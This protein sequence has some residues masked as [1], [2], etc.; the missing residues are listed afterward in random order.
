MPSRCAAVDLART[1]VGPYVTPRREVLQPRHDARAGAPGLASEVAQRALDDLVR[2]RVR[3]RRRCTRRGP[4]ARGR[5]SARRSRPRAPLRGMSCATSVGRVAATPK[6]ERAEERAVRLE[7][8][9]RLAR[10]TRRSTC[11]GVRAAPGR[12]SSRAGRRDGGRSRRARRRCRAG[13]GDGDVDVVLPDGRVREVRETAVAGVRAAVGRLDD[14][15]AL[16]ALP[17]GRREERVAE[18][19]EAADDAD[20]ARVQLRDAVAQVVDVLRRRRS[21]RPSGDGRVEAHLARLVLEVDLDRVDPVLVD[22]LDHATAQ[23]RV[24]PAVQ[25]DVH[26]AYR[27]GGRRGMMSTAHAAS[28]AVSR[29]ID[30]LQQELSWQRRREARREATVVDWAARPAISRRARARPSL[31]NERLARP[32]GGGT[33]ELD[34]RRRRVDGEAPATRRLRAEEAAA[35][36]DLHSMLP[37]SEAHRGEASGSSPCV[38]PS[39]RRRC[40]RAVHRTLLAPVTVNWSFARRAASRCVP[41]AGPVAF[42]GGAKTL[43]APATEATRRAIA[44]TTASGDYAALAD[45]RS[46]HARTPGP[47]FQPLFRDNRLFLVQKSDTSVGSI[48]CSCARG[49]GRSSRATIDRAAD[50][51][52]AV[53]PRRAAVRAHFKAADRSSALARSSAAAS[54]VSAA[55]RASGVSTPPP[56]AA[57]W[58]TCCKCDGS[59]PGD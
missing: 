28:G 37:V 51:S 49:S 31:E 2:L 15:V 32:G 46:G 59:M 17:G 48:G 40:R 34:R 22:Q 6:T 53:S 45:R 27:L 43:R 42:R 13:R 39:R 58:R 5:P 19:D 21:A 20:P 38:S 52:V 7:R 57:Q 16:A 24:G 14:L 56:S 33:V 12:P 41:L 36:L 8:E 1:S 54:A 35:S 50:R 47:S 25:R 30:R 23:R 4:S 44:P 9:A 29:E 3:V 55:A 11:S 18:A 26:R 10:G